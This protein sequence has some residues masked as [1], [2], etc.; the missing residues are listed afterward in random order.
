[1]NDEKGS[2][3]RCAWDGDASSWQ[4]Y[5]RKARLMFERTPRKRRHL[6]GPELLSQL[7][8]R[9]WVATQEIDHTLPVRRTGVID[10]L[11]YLQGKL[12]KG[13]IPDVGT[14]LEAY[15]QLQMALG[16]VLKGQ[17]TEDP[18]SPRAPTTSSPV[19][20]FFIA[21]VRQAL[22]IALEAI[23]AAQE[24]RDEAARVRA[25][26]L[27]L[28][29][30]RLLLAR[31]A[32]SGSEGRAALVH[33]IELF[34][35][36][37]FEALHAQSVAARALARPRRGGEDSEETRVGEALRTSK[38]G[39]AAGLSGAT[40]EL[41]KLLLDD[42]DA[43]EA[44]AFAAN[45][46][47][48][49]EDEPQ[50][51]SVTEAETLPGDGVL[52]DDDDDDL[53]E[54]EEADP[55]SSCARCCYLYDLARR[56]RKQD[57]DSDSS[58]RA[59]QDLKLWEEYTE[60]LEEALPPELLGRTFWVEEQGH[61]SL[62]MALEED[63]ADVLE[64]DWEQDP[65]ESLSKEETAEVNEAYS[66]ADNKLR[67]FVQARQAVK[68]QKL[69][70]GF[71][72]F[73]PSSKG[74]GGGKKGMR[75]EKGKGKR[76]Q[77]GA[78][79]SGSP[80]S[81]TSMP[82]LMRE[83]AFA[84]RPGDPSYTGCFICGDRGHQFRDC[85][86][87]KGKGKGSVHFSQEDL[88]WMD[89]DKHNHEHDAPDDIASDYMIQEITT[90]PDHDISSD[91][92][93][94][95]ITTAPD[96]DISSDYMSQEITAA[97]DHDIPSDYM[98]QDIQEITA[99][100]DHDIVL[101]Y[102]IQEANVASL[103]PSEIPSA[104]I[105][106]TVL[107]QDQREE[108]EM[109]DMCLSAQTSEQ[110]GQTMRPFAILTT[111]IA[112]HG[113]S[114]P[115]CNSKHGA[116][117]EGR[118]SEISIK[119]LKHWLGSGRAHCREPADED[120][121]AE[122]TIEG[123]GSQGSGRVQ[124]RKA[125]AQGERRE[126]STRLV[127][128]ERHLDR[129]R[130]DEAPSWKEGSAGQRSDGGEPGVGQSDY[131]MPV[132]QDQ[133]RV[134]KLA[135]ELAAQKDWSMQG[136]EKLVA[137]MQVTSSQLS[138]GMQ[139]GKT[140]DSTSVAL[141]MYSR[142]SFSKMTKGTRQLP[143][144][145]LCI[146][147]W[148]REQ[149]ELRDATWTSVNISVNSE[150]NPH[151]DVHNLNGTRNY[152][153][154]SD[155]I[156][157]SSGQRALGTLRP[158]WHQVVAFDP[159]TWHATMRWTGRRVSVVACTARLIVRA[160]AGPWIKEARRAVLE[161]GS[162]VDSTIGDVLERG[163]FTSIGAS[164]AEGCDFSTTKGT[165]MVLE[166]VAKVRPQWTV[167]HLPRGPQVPEDHPRLHELQRR[168][169]KVLGNFLK[170]ARRVMD[171]GGQVVW[172]QPHNGMIQDASREVREFWRQ[173]QDY[174]GGH[175]VSIG[176]HRV[177][178]TS[179]A[180][181]RSLPHTNDG[182]IDARP[183][184]AELLKEIHFMPIEDVMVT[185]AEK[186][187]LA[188]MEEKGLRELM[189]QT[190]KVQTDQAERLWEVLQID[191]FHQ[192]IG[193]YVYH[194]LIMQDE[195]ATIL[196]EAWLQYF[197]APSVLKGAL[198]NLLA[199]HEPIAEAERAI[200]VLK[201]KIEA[202]LRTSPVDPVRAALA[203]VMTHNT[204]VRIHGYSP[205]RWTLG[206]DFGP[207][208][209]VGNDPGVLPA[210][211][212]AATPGTE[213]FMNRELRLKAAQSFLEYRD[214]VYYQRLKH[215]S[216]LPSNR[217]VDRP[218]MRTTRWFGPARVLA[219]ETK[220]DPGDRKP[221][222]QVWIIASGCL[223]KAHVSQLRHASET[224]RLIS[225]A[226]G[227]TVF[228]WT[229]TSLT[230]S[231]H[232][233]AYEDLTVPPR[234]PEDLRLPDT[235]ELGEELTEEIDY[236]PEPREPMMVD[237]RDAR[238]LVEDYE[239]LDVERLL[240]DPDYLPTVLEAQNMSVFTPENAVFAVT[241]P[242]P[243]DTAEWKK[244]VKNP[245]KFAEVSWAKSS[246]AQREAMNEAKGMEVQQ[247][248][249]TKVARKVKEYVDPT[250]LIRMRWVLTFKNADPDDRGNLQMKA[251]A[252]I[253]VL[254]Y[255]SPSLLKEPTTSPTMSRLSRQLILNMVC[256]KGW[257]IACA[258][259]KTA[260]LQA[261]PQERQQR[262]LA[263]PLPELAEAM[264][265]A[266]HTAVELTGSAYG[267]A[268][269]PREWFQD[270]RETVKKLGAKACRTDPCV[271]RIY[272][273]KGKV[274]GIFASYVDD[275]LLAGNMES[276][277]WKKFLDE[278]K[279][280]YTWSPWEWDEFDHCGIHLTRYE[281]GSVQIDHAAFCKELAELPAPP[282]TSRTM[283]DAEL[284][285]ARAV[286]GSVQWRVTQSGPQHAAKLGYLQSLLAKKDTECITQIN[287]LVREVQAARHLSPQVQQLNW[288]GEDLTF[289]GW[290]DASS[291]AAECQALSITEQEL[292]WSRLSWRELLGDDLELGKATEIAKR[293]RAHLI[294]DARGV[295]DALMK[296]AD[297]SEGF[298]LRDK[299][300]ALDLMGLSDQIRE[301]ETVLE[302]C[303]SDWQLADGLTKA[304]KQ[305]ALKRFLANG[306]W[307]LRLPGA[308]MSAQRRKAMEN[309]M[310]DMIIL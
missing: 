266:P 122:A 57:S 238:E 78:S 131:V 81:A 30:P 203:M 23:R 1:M 304:S 305:D 234:A 242:A 146:N 290:S 173:Y 136:M 24:G 154:S 93:I 49:A 9:A 73:V 55:T 296:G 100:S 161:F 215:P 211:A 153:V 46:A 174:H 152:A 33:R 134:E 274:C 91:Y 228:L 178:S 199:D 149:P 297:F 264:G 175:P 86:R 110:V 36:S 187:V 253:V 92:M 246:P 41:Y 171:D 197:G 99:A 232:R 307:K 239:P 284:S 58:Q 221:A 130:P 77:K 202:F 118:A 257:R 34:R 205:L 277:S 5:V 229:M 166:L 52:S 216:D 217:L 94:Q 289:I 224:E 11:Q 180:M 37:R 192:Q 67:S 59:L 87:R 138:R 65:T 80:A 160:Q 201:P 10:L 226:S 88:Y 148:L 241:I 14:R 310:N 101:D 251:K 191:M 309:S 69:S 13:V 147:A 107:L 60:V 194:F 119:N 243:K 120:P 306:T 66:V 210:M 190:D 104:H 281:D 225:E 85:P 158:T 51:E 20:R 237:E 90:A 4:D 21:G 32:H 263:R 213:A 35:Q 113:Y 128:F 272:D 142:G 44:F 186:D 137:A 70:R 291:L 176:A 303:D 17:R 132:F 260:F 267:L 96:H 231:L 185:Q 278:F 79:G 40:V 198:R 145:C 252:R 43:L 126:R 143:K 302:W 95:E 105:E 111:L 84:M 299:Y 293:T 172:L 219:T 268:Q 115:A 168:F 206:R 72:P 209:K 212:A 27:F 308:F 294:I 162:T 125:T 283:T 279:Q 275:F 167:C 262:L 112:A 170:V 195:V 25:W 276:A 68:A 129:G 220:G 48:R 75:K 269:A 116:G 265:L 179:A 163:G 140:K 19:P 82:I 157:L 39:S 233:G 121:R 26:K 135:D 74:I 150:S 54:T 169:Y 3:Y 165:Q 151:R 64:S 159:D 214:L 193:D 61:W 98:I 106:D 230:A 177:R 286:L 200:G 295:Y 258:D 222:A 144:V 271:W 18:G 285:Q 208:N 236:R 97:P 71:Y 102:M 245:E 45:V 181:L 31:S 15:R 261:R 16:R 240:N 89:A 255:S 38:R 280:A 127:T 298:N 282:T 8:G 182:N 62:L 124:E 117:G 292:M 139:R 42:A 22:V 218:R 123:I 259:V 227:T 288:P 109:V 156:R 223:K 29:L 28:L 63:M 188:Q 207:G 250:S 256:A 235:E 76:P 141:G 301:Q 7:T 83:T 114:G 47:A 183:R 300:S 270:I 103:G 196:D 133:D 108:G 12:G 247:W 189:V 244:L 53:V 50:H 204:Q 248:L 287:K 155:L 254:G 184:V 273:D 164:F 6:L 249:K 2:K 56:P